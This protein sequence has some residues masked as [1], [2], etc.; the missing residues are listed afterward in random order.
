[1]FGLS[2][3]DEPD[4]NPETLGVLGQMTQVA[5]VIE[6][7]YRPPSVSEVR[8][9]LFKLL[10]VQAEA[11]RQARRA[12]EVLSEAKMPRL[13]ILTPT[14]SA[15]LLSGFAAQEQ[16]EWPRGVYC[17]PASL[18]SGVIVI[19]QLLETPETLWLRLLG[20]GRVQQQA[21]AEVL[22]LPLGD[23]RRMT[24][25]RVL[26]NWKIAIEMTV[27]VDEEDEEVLMSLTQAYLEWERETERRGIEQGIEQGRQQGE[28]A[29]IMRMLKRRFEVPEAIETEVNALS[30]ESLEELGEAFLDFTSLDDLVAWLAAHQ[31][32]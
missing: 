9:C 28:S 30:I 12:G 6:P 2:Q 27:E 26:S 19:H 21:I 5:S 10:Q 3:I 11:Q 8:R 18:R 16:A 15:E 4:V 1:M 7:Y 29:L 31:E 32:Q 24:A 17:L 25:L 20:K 14:A 13:W 22:A 23:E